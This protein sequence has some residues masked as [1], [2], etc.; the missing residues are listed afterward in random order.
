MVFAAQKL[1]KIASLKSPTVLV[2]VDRT[3]LDTNISSAFN[4]SDIPNVI[5]TESIKELNEL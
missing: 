1:R 2:L 5:G 4:A 3:D